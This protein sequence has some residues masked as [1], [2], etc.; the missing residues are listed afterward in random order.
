LGRKEFILPQAYN[1]AVNGFFVVVPDA[2]GHGE[3]SGG[4]VIKLFDSILN[5]TAEID[6]LIENYKD[7]EDADNTRIGLSGYSMGGC[8]TFLYLAQ[9]TKRIKAAVPVISTPDWV[10]II[11][12]FSTKEKLEELKGYGI[13]KDDSDITEYRQ[14]AERIEPINHYEAMKNIPLLMLCGG[15]DMVT[16]VS[17]PQR[18]Y[19]MLKPLTSDA[20]ALK[21]M[22]YPRA[23]HGDTVEMNFEMTDWM[24]KYLI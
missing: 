3:R 6:G 16:P 19:E 14:T 12:G 1:L 17:G 11:D 22:I 8:I 18:L 7:H 15:M 21:L 23:A 24:K 5:S 20:A 13:I 4:R 10:S 2:Y 9:R